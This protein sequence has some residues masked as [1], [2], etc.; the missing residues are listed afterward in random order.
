MREF[1]S[2]E[3]FMQF[4]CDGVV[5]FVMK[6]KNIGRKSDIYGRNSHLLRA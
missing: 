5:P 6:K 2:A 3:D 4:K 1:A